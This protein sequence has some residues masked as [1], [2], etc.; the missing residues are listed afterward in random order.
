MIIRNAL[1]LSCCCL[2]AAFGASLA[3]GS[4]RGQSNANARVLLGRISYDNSYVADEKNVP[5]AA[6][7]CLEVYQDG[8]YRMARVGGNGRDANVGGVL[9][10]KQLNEI[11]RL[12]RKI[13]FQNNQLGGL[14]RRGS[15]TFVAEI[16]RADKVER[17]IWIDADHQKPFPESA[18]R[19]VDWLREFKAEGTKPLPSPD[20]STMQICPRMSQGPLT[21]VAS[22]GMEDQSSCESGAGN[23]N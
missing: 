23:L 3:F 5:H 19:I 13:D 10:K 4:A 11:S 9:D 7:I 15:E 12:F 17:F 14:V 6:R 18:K 20:L 2:L 21:P 8:V 16:T 1:S 22:F